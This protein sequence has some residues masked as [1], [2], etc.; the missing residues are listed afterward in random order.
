M[1]ER[2]IE[3]VLASMSQAREKETNLELL[4]LLLLGVRAIHRSGRPWLKVRRHAK[5]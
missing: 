4:P 2:D 5:R 3:S 1:Q